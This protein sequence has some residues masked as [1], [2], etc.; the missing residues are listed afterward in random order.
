MPALN[1]Q[2]QS[3]ERRAAILA[4]VTG[5]TLM[6]AK[7]VAYF[8][9]GSVAIF[10]DA[11]ESIGNVV[12]SGVAFYALRIAHAPPDAQHPYGH[13][14]VEFLSAALEGGMICAAAGAIIIKGVHDLSNPELKS[15]ALGLGL[16]II[17]FSAL[18]N[19][20][21]GLTLIRQGRRTGSAT[22]AADGL[23]LMTDSVTSVAALVALGVVRFTGWEKA[24]PI[25]A[26][27]MA[28][29]LVSAGGVMLKRSLDMLMDKQDPRDQAMLGALLSAHVGPAGTSP[30]I[31][32]FHKLRH[33]HTGRYHWVDLHVMVPPTTDVKSAHDAVSAI[34][35]EIER[36]LGEGDATAHIEP[37]DNA[38]CSNCRAATS[39]GG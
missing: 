3:A 39:G 5:V 36:A 34:E 28:V 4:V 11:M 9:T 19:G 12:A 25:T 23:H 26:L 18:A 6:A 24:D 31:C 30:Q 16:A 37:C 22:L 15:E 10:S 27:L 29:Y 2:V 1:S 32:S 38:G 8:L 14:K 20:A 13:G 17:A 21:V 33:R 7:F 35:G